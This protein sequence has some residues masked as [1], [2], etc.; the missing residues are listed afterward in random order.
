MQEQLVEVVLQ[1]PGVEMPL[2]VEQVAVV[3]TQ[4]V[5][6]AGKLVQ[7][8]GKLEVVE[9]QLVQLAGDLEVVG[10]VQAAGP[11]SALLLF[12]LPAAPAEY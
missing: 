12:A 8:A 10:S 3:E 1:L 7:L 2:A 4:L 5:Q 6:L 9:P 11:T